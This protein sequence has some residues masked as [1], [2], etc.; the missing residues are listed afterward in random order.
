MEK[1]AKGP[2]LARMPYSPPMGL[3]TSAAMATAVLSVA[4]VSAQSGPRA[5]TFADDIAPITRSRCLTC[6][7]SGG[8]APFSLA[9][10]DDVRRR[11]S[12]IVA[13]MKS[14]YM[15]P[16]KPVDGFGDFQ[17]ARRMTTDEIAIIDR[18]V[19][20]GM[21]PGSGPHLAPAPDSTMAWERGEPD[22]VL[23]LPIYTLR[24]DGRDIFRNF[25][26]AVPVAATRYVR[27]LQFRPRSRAVHHANIR[28]DSTSGSRRLDEADPM[29]GYE[30]LI[31]RSADFPD[32]HFLGWTPG[33][34]APVLS[35]D[36]SWR[37]RPGAD[38]VVQLHLRP[39]GKPE[40]IAPI[41]GFYF[42]DREPSKTPTMI[43]LGRQ[44]L[45]IPP[46]ASAHTISDSFVLPTAVEVHAIQPHAHYRARSMQAWAN[47]PDGSRRPLIRIDDW[48]MNWQDRY[49]YVSPF[50]LPAGTRVT[51]DYV[52]DNSVGNVRNPDRPP[53]RARWGW[54]SADEMADL[55][56][57]VMTDSDADRA[58]LTREISIKMF[59]ED[60]IGSEVVLEREPNHVN[61]RNDAARLYLALG[62]PARALL[63]FEAVRSLQP[64][65]APALFNEGV[66]L[67]AQERLAEA[68]ARYA[69]ALRID[70][71]H[72][73]AHNNTG[74]LL[75]REG[76]IAE[77]R[78]A[79]E[80]AVAADPRNTDAQANLGLAMI[81]TAEPDAGLE[82]IRLALDVTPELLTGMVPHVWL[83][84]AHSNPAA[85]RP[86]EARTLAER[87]LRAT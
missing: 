46:D 78:S 35:D 2:A 37:L 20:N 42:S 67:E 13:V 10:L 65:S 55:W 34:L 33:Q 52:F 48:D 39:T 25:V 82:H 6:H 53:V 87:I 70:P 75:L 28:V 30:G 66:A 26:V 24:A 86:A 58:R 77:A 36:S 15:P 85:R 79:F 72:S 17:G 49:V 3:S 19:R 56:I 9:S 50:R 45:D 47:L 80:R 27:G 8:D 43:R 18:W 84:A 63:H 31:A 21:A 59:T 74:T 68:K 4:L 38:L 54:R 29:P 40:E 23:S 60:A 5:V 16:W 61:L 1:L 81:A 11:A 12:M 7:T 51:L 32:G 62:Q 71:A 41:I 73:P 14:G 44:D 76:R 69:E 64:G 83:L 57:Q 22:L